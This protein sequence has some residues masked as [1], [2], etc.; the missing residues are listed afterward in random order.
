MD[1]EDIRYC[2]CCGTAIPEGENYSWIGDEI[3]CDDCR[4]N[5][6]GCC[7]CCDELIYNSEAITDDG[8]FVCRSCQKQVKKMTYTFSHITAIFDK[9]YS[10]SL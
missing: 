8:H 3:V 4:R 7:E 10:S 2:D 9:F 6:C 5:E 1:E